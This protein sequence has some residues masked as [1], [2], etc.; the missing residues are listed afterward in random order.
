MYMMS[1]KVPTVPWGRS[2][3]GQLFDVEEEAGS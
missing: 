3:G 2:G 1:V